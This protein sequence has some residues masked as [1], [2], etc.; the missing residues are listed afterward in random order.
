MNRQEISE[1]AHAA[2]QYADTI[3]DALNAITDSALI[4][5]RNLRYSYLAFAV[6]RLVDALHRHDGVED[7]EDP[8]AW[9]IRDEIIIYHLRVFAEADRAVGWMT[10][11]VGGTPCQ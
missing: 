4:H 10:R 7:K 1:Q 11:M 8:K 3:M 5:G 6:T 2:L 9:A